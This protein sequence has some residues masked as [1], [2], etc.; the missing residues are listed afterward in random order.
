MSRHSINE[1]LIK[2]SNLTLNRR[3][4]GINSQLNIYKILVL[5]RKSTEHYVNMLFC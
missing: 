5:Q 2:N 3:V 1:L 4:K